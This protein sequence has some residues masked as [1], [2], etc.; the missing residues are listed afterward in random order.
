LVLL[1]PALVTLLFISSQTGI[2]RH[3][4]YALPILPFLF[5]WVSSLASLWTLKAPQA[6][7]LWLRE[8]SLAILAAGCLGWSVISSALVYPH[9]L[10]YFNELVGGPRG[11]SRYL[12]GSSTDW[13]QDMLFL[14]AWIDNHPEARPLTMR[15][16]IPHFRPQLAGIDFPAPPDFPAPGWHIVSVNQIHAQDPHYRYFLDF[17]PVNTIG[18][19]LNVYHLSGEQIE[20]WKQKQ[21]T[22]SR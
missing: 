19:S 10:S 1:A 2:N 12:L 4:R 17:E 6:G 18:Y 16:H 13:G 7:R 21:R 14:K 3:F 5:I 15:W 20:D 11:G 9:S 22:E 8:R